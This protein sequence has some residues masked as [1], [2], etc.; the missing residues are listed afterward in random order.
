LAPCHRRTLIF[1]GKKMT[2]MLQVRL[3]VYGDARGENL[4]YGRGK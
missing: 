2:A 3:D 4:L 1:Y